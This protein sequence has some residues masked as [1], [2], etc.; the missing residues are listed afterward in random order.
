MFET[1]IGNE[2]VKMFISKLLRNGRFP[3]AVLFAGPDG[4]GKRA[5]ALETAKA[6]VCRDGGCDNCAACQRVGR[7][8]IPKP[9]RKD[10]FKVVIFTEH[11]DV[12]MVVPFNRNI[13]VDAVRDLEGQAHFRPYEAKARVF[14]V[15]NADKMND[16]ASNALLKTLEEPASTS[17]LILVSSR[18]DSLLQTIRSRCQ[19]VRFAP[20]PTNEIEQLLT[21]T[22]KFAH[23]DAALAARL[24]GGSVAKALATD[25]EKLRP[26]R[27][28]M[29]AVI[30]NAVSNRTAAVLQI[31]ERMN[32]AKHK[33]D[34]EE[35]LAIL[36]GLIRDVW[37]L[38]HGASPG[39]LA[40]ADI[41]DRL[42]PL[43]GGTPASTFAGWMNEIELMRERFAVNI[44][45]KIATDA[46]FVEMANSA[47]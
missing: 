28:A 43:A 27:D 4:V 32:D 25:V 41:V 13:L 12:G 6:F 26:A 8:N 2:P 31:A 9:D 19:T 38:A 16:A 7:L 10:D 39:E 33:D 23:D 24:S 45:R 30:E 22:G 46:L 29:L 44:N 20:V 37:L 15:D 18:P 40:N 21:A 47:V 5:F 42:R 1:L 34:L 35:N 17:F 36:E 3:N 14:I 11:P